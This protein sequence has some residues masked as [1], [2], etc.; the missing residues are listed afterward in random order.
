[1]PRQRINDR[2]L[3]CNFHLLD[4][5][6]SLN[7]PP[8][9]FTPSAGFS[10]I[11]APEMTIEFE[12]I[13]E[14]NGLFPYKVLTKG[15]VNTITLQRGVSAFNSD[16]WRWIVSCQQG[17]KNTAATALEFI[18]GA[19]YPSA[20]RRNIMILHLSGMSFD[21]VKDA[22]RSGGTDAIRGGLYSPAGAI[23]RALEEVSSTAGMADIGLK[24]IPAKA[25]ILRGCLPVRYK[26]GSDFDATASDVS[27]EELEITYHHFEEFA[28]KA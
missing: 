8:W 22:L 25:Y 10:S 13:D 17:N 2:L 28:F 12:E 16:F 21:A 1:M 23:T 24:S 3:A 15:T 18:K 20:K 4:V 7:V 11:T 14:G 19:F 6:F 5:D 9:V 27:L 26:V